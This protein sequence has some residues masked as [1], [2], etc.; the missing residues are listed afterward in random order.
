MKLLDRL[1]QRWRIEKVRRFIPSSARVL[2]IGCSDGML[3]RILGQKLGEG[4]GIEPD[5]RE[6]VRANRYNLLPGLF[7]EA[8][9]D[10]RPFDV[11]TLMAVLEHIPAVRQPR[12]A[13]AIAAALTPGGLVLVTVPSPKV[14]RILE[15]L[16]AARLIDGMS[17]EQHF[18]F[19]VDQT[20]GLF[21]NAGLKLVVNKKFQLGLNNLFVFRACNRSSAHVNS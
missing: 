21:E 12:F 4:T 1:L 15:A 10:T 8:L 2:D 20:P 7:P 19:R 9:P 16:K 5:L 11:I 14:D 17:L 6:A 18:G 13:E 3:F